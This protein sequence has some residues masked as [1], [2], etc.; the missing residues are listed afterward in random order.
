MNWN[1]QFPFLW[2]GYSLIWIQVAFPVWITPYTSF[3]LLPPPSRQPQSQ[4]FARHVNISFSMS[5][6]AHAIYTANSGLVYNQ[7]PIPLPDPEGLPLKVKYPHQDG[8]IFMWD[9]TIHG[10]LDYEKRIDWYNL[11]RSVHSKVNTY[12]EVDEPRFDPRLHLD[13]Q[14][15]EYIRLLTDFEKTKKYPKVTDHNGSSFAYS[16]PFQACVM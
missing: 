13:L 16:S 5:H 8:W 14:H 2:M 11:I 6:T 7:S 12:D 10:S 4:I 1:S 15:P 3:S 9:H